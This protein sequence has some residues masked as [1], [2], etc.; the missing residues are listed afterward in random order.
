[1]KYKAIIFDV[2]GAL[3][4]WG[5]CQPDKISVTYKLE[6]PLDILDL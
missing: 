3:G 5:A 4:L 2:D 6:S 1:M